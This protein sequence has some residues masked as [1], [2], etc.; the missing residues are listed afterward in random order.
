MDVIKERC[1]VC[2][3]FGKQT[4]WKNIPLDEILGTLEKVEV[5]CEACKGKGYIE[6]AVF[7]REEATAILEYCNLNKD[8]PGDEAM[9]KFYID[10]KLLDKE[11]LAAIESAYSDYENGEII[12]AKRT[13]KAIIKAIE[14]F[15]RDYETI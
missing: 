10:G 11:I 13:F 7:S 8:K 9:E 12:E 14:A 1:K 3:G 6:Y 4:N 5:E 2:D 15:E